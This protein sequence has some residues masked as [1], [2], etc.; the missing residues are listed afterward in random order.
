MLWS[1]LSAAPVEIPA[2]QPLPGCGGKGN[3]VC[4]EGDTAEARRVAPLPVGADPAAAWGRL[5]AAL[6]ELGGDVRS[7]DGATL[8]AVFT[9]PV[10]RFPDDLHARL[11]AGAGVIHLRSQSRVGRGDLGANRK[12]VEKLRAAYLREG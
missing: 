8:H 12:R 1:L 7:D 3:C 4:S 5:R 9:T 11:D 2:G 10:L 6:D